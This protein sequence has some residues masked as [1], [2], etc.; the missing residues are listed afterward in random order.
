LL[1][2][3]RWSFPALAAVIL[4]S[5]TP[6][7][8]G[9]DKNTTYGYSSLSNITE[10]DDNSAFGYYALLG[11]QSGSNNTGTGSGALLR[12][13]AGNDNTAMGKF[14]LSG[15]TG[16][17]NTATGSGALSG[18]GGVTTGNYNTATGF[19][20]LYSITTGG[21]NV[22]DGWQ[23]LYSNTSG[24]YNTA[25]GTSALRQNAT[26][27]KNTASGLNSLYYNNGQNN[28]AYGAESLQNNAGGN[29]NTALGYDAMFYNSH[30]SNN[31]AVGSQAGLNTTGN[32]NIAIGNPGVAGESGRI[33]IGTAGKQTDTLIAGIYGKTIASGAQVIIGSGGKFGT[34]LSSARYK[35]AIKP[36]DKASEAILALEPVTF[37]YKHD[38][39]P[40]GVTQFGL[41]AEQVE[42]VHPDLVVRDEDG[43]VSTVRYETVNAM[44]LNEFLKEHRKVQELQT[45][46]AKQEALA[47]EQQ[48][49]IHALTAGLQEVKARKSPQH[50]K[51]ISE[52]S[53]SIPIE[54][55]KVE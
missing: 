19:Q 31:I 25:T 18:G 54:P 36:M 14:A 29:N 52:L 35:E 13:T 44:L 51:L 8:E 7:S 49:Q 6:S 9:Q 41:I 11:N 27:S 43:K 30:G 5:L 42:K 37:R 28:S 34:V 40:D 46:V 2:A 15:C 23:A 33:R 21:G 22:A 38:L 12:N 24:V 45:A 39:D 53:R 16:S 10:G 1:L 4:F 26:G 3:R 17:Q 55:G 50:H 20:S 32:N 48:K 47:A